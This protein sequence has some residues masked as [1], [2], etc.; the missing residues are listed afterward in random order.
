[1]LAVSNQA[2]CG[3]V[4]SNVGFYFRVVF[5]V[6]TE[7]DTYAFHTPTDF[8]NGGFSMLDGEF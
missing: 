3:G 4:D 5:P 7:N 6:G 1:M 2:L 8:G